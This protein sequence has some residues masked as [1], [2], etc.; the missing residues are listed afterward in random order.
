MIADPK[1]DQEIQ[2]P[3]NDGH[4][5]GLR[6]GADRLDDL[7]QVHARPGR[8]RDV[9]HH[10]VAQRRPVDVDAIAPDNAVTLQPGQ[11]VRD[12]RGRHLDRPGQ[13]PLRLPRVAGERAQQC[14]VQVVH[15][16]LRRHRR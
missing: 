14:Q 7:A 9:H 4:V 5:L 10:R 11:P 15:L 12:R 6:Q 8:H 2:S 1:P 13:R 3:G 16:D